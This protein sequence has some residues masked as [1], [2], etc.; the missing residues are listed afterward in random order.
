MR[1]ALNRSGFLITLP[2]LAW[3][4]LI[5]ALNRSKKLLR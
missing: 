3:L 2:L 5:A 1:D 4:R